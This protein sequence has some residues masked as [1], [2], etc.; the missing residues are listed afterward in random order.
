V[1]TARS[2][3]SPYIKQIRF[4][5]KGLNKVGRN[6]SYGENEMLRTRHYQCYKQKQQSE[7]CAALLTQF[8]A[9]LER[10]EQDFWFQQ[11]GGGSAS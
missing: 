5:F 10:K 11:G 7:N 2:A 4:V 8:I 1:F 9:L 6:I 3:L